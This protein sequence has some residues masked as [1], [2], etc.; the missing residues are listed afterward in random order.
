[1][2]PPARSAYP[3][4]I[5]TAPAPSHI[6]FARENDS[7]GRGGPVG[8]GPLLGR[9]DSRRVEFRRLVSVLAMDGGT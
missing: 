8:L 2:L 7:V 5:T 6:A 1:M 3:I 9:A 4:A